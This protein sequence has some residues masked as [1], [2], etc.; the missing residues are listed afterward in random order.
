MRRP[1]LFRISAV[2]GGRFDLDGLQG[3]TIRVGRAIEISQFG[4]PRGGRALVVH[5]DHADLRMRALD[6]RGASCHASRC[7]K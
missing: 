1:L 2:V 3:D 7:G 5:R 6:A 4:R